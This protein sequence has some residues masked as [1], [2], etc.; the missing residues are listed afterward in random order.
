[1]A[2][3]LYIFDERSE[4]IEAWAHGSPKAALARIDERCRGLK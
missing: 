3:K 1:M 2:K 4:I